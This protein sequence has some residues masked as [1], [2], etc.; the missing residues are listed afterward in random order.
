MPNWSRSM[1]ACSLGKASNGLVAVG[2][3][4]RLVQVF[5]INHGTFQDF[6]GHSGA[7]DFVSFN[8]DAT[9]LFSSSFNEI[10]VWK[11]LL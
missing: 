11:L 1:H 4:S 6:T 10:F 8:K 5:D 3:D 2:T 7:V 9:K